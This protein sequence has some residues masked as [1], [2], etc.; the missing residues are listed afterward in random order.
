MHRCASVWRWQRSLE[1]PLPK[2]RPP[3]PHGR[4]FLEAWYVAYNGG[5][6]AGVAKLFT[7]DA[8]FGP[9][10]GR[11]AIAADLK[12]A[13]AVTTYHCVGHFEALHELHALA[14]ASGVETCVE[15]PK[16]NGSPVTTKER[17]LVVFERQVDGRWLISRE[18]SEDLRP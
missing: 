15:T 8:R 1:A 3:F 12:K 13:F 18:T 9:H 6:A 17:W 16:L 5:D 14:V 7:V 11:A 10:K 2:R 4:R